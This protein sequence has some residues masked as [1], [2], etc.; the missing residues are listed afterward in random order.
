MPST[1]REKKNKQTNKQKK[2]DKQNYTIAK[3]QYT[4]KYLG[5]YNN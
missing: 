5:V 1:E 3:Y 2:P 4:G